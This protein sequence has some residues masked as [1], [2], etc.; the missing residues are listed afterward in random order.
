MGILFVL[1]KLSGPYL[2]FQLENYDQ[3]VMVRKVMRWITHPAVM[4]LGCSW[5]KMVG[6]ERRRQP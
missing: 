5:I 2:G 6:K 3:D 4:H 1:I